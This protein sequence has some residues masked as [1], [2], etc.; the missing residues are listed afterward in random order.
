MP[1]SKEKSAKDSKKSAPKGKGADHA[2][3]TLSGAINP[4]DSEEGGALT[5]YSGEESKATRELVG[6]DED[7]MI[8]VH[9]ERVEGKEIASPLESLIAKPKGEEETFSF[10]GEESEGEESEGEESEDEAAE[11]HA[12]GEFEIPDEYFNEDGRAQPYKGA[13]REEIPGLPEGPGIPG[14]GVGTPKSGPL[15]PPGGGRD[16]D[17]G[18]KEFPTS[19]KKPTGFWKSYGVVGL[20]GAPGGEG[21]QEERKEIGGYGNVSKDRG[22]GHISKGKG[23]WGALGSVDV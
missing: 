19:I 23:T 22:E 6:F 11:R 9:A 18:G 17:G 4:L 15:S 16:D 10:E 5:K 8:P 3:Y 14:G 1:K 7:A 2:I 12:K 21:D 13:E 20:K